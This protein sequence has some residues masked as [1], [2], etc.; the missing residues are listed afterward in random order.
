MATRDQMFPSRFLK[1]PDLKGK[2]SVVEI[3]SAE[4]E[5]LKNPQGQEQT[6]IVLSFVG[7]QKVLP[8]NQ[9][10]FDSCVDITGQIDSDDWVGCKIEIYPTKT[11]M[12]G[13]LVD[14][15][16][17]RAPEQGELPVAEKKKKSANA[18]PPLGDEMDDQIPF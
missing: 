12:G 1:A 16:R 11:Q 17:I 5:T 9:V 7:K 8:L 6:K 14:A 10:N 13:K 2:P 3:A 18:K 15:V 4:Q